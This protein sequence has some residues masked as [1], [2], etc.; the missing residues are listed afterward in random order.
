MLKMVEKGTLMI[1]RTV[2]YSGTKYASRSRQLTLAIAKHSNG[3]S[4]R[5]QRD[6]NA[7]CERELQ[8]HEYE[9]EI[10]APDIRNFNKE[11]NQGM[12]P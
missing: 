9:E 10:Y 8:G 2:H 4:L 5:S 3:P 12:D 11:Q 6:L 7:F 1:F